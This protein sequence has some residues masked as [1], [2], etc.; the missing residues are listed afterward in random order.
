[1]AR[2]ASFAGAGSPA[3][4]AGIFEPR[5]GFRTDFLKLPFARFDG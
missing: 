3:W 5:E 1:L 4:L 2:F